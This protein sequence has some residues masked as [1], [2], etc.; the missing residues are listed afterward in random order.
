[1]LGYSGT[2]QLV[3]EEALLEWTGYDRPGD[4][5]KWLREKGIRFEE[6]KGKKV[7][8]TLSAVNAVFCPILG[9]HPSDKFDI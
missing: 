3:S 4:L 9:A 8:T 7:V 1:M 6:G 2:G 5:K